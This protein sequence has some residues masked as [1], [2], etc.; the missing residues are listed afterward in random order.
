MA[1]KRRGRSEG[2]VYQRGDGLWVGSLSLGYDGN[3]KRRRRTVYGQT[4]REAQQELR[5]LQ[6]KVDIGQSVDASKITVSEY[7]DHWLSRVKSTVATHT[8]LPYK[9]HVEKYLKPKIG[10]TKLTALAAVH[11]EQLYSELAEAGVSPAMQHKAGV[12]LNVALQNAVSPLKLIPFNPVRE[13]KKPR[14]EPKE[15]TAL[16]PEQAQR[17]LAE[18]RADG[19]FPLYAFLLD[20]GAREGEAFALLWSD[21]D[22]QGAAVQIMRNLEETAGKLKVKDLKTKKSR[23]RVTLTGFTMDAIQDHRKAML[24]AGLYRPDGKVFC[25][26]A[27]GYLRKSN[28]LRRSFRPI[29]KRAKL[30][31][32][33]PYD[34]R[35]TSAT[36]L[37]LA[38]VDVKVVSERLGHSSARLTQDTYQH[39]LPGMQERAAAQLEAIFRTPAKRLAEIG[40]S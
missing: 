4:K 21:F 35:H 36:L 39:V 5:E 8:Y 29:L 28:V 34:L 16:D 15:M 14:H 25:D 22:F 18:A 20:S 12:T 38:G 3:G 37:L 7:L 30:P 23:R 26:T 2:A 13:V 33:R 40:Y 19:L 24:A 27:G 11:V 32:I 1:R 9:Q 10:G 6:T 17:F 31:E